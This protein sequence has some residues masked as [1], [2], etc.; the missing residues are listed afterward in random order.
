MRARPGYI[1]SSSACFLFLSY[2]LY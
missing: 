1:G 2:A